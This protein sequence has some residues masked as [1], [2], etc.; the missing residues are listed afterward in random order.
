MTWLQVNICG[1]AC[2]G[3][4][5][6]DWFFLCATVDDTGTMEHTSS[7]I[8]YFHQNVFP[9]YAASNQPMCPSDLI[10]AVTDGHGSHMSFQFLD[11][12]HM[13]PV[14]LVMRTP[15]TIAMV[16]GGEWLRGVVGC[17]NHG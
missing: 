17:I 11:F 6:P 4:T 12:C 10:L 1:V 8:G 2:P 15:H 13:A 3:N 7:C 14:V 16:G 9:T 5:L